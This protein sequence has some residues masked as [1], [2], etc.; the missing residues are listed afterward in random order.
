M[1]S[2]DIAEFTAPEC[3][4]K[5]YQNAYEV[6]KESYADNLTLGT[7]YDAPERTGYCLMTRSAIGNK[8]SRVT[9]LSEI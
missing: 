2:K 7:I 6:S 1:G 3:W 4:Q 5:V 8:D 9:L